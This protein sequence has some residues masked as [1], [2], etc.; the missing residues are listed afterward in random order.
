MELAKLKIYV[1][2]KYPNFDQLNPIE[3][4]F[5]P[6][7]IE[8]SKTGWQQGLGG[9]LVAADRSA[10]LSLELFF[11]T[12]LPIP[13]S[14]GFSLLQPSVKDIGLA[15]LP[16]L[17]KFKIEKDV[18]DYTQRIYQ[19]TQKRGDLD[20]RPPICQLVWGKHT[21]LFQGVLT[22]LTKSFTKFSADGTP[23]RATLR[24]SFEEWE[25]PATT[26]KKINPIDDPVRVVKRGETL[27]SIAAEEYNDP[28][29]WRIIAVTN[30]I[31]NPRRLTP[32]QRLTVPPLPSNQ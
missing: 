14:T 15:L 1:E 4:L 30:K 19:L 25:P 6:N 24:C 29:L 9:N 20:Q 23:I 5:N 16:G 28:N 18:R 27:S 13:K 22:Q 26:Q 11:D 8:I 17:P 10:T 32:G 3:A 2:Q 21:V 12:S 31:D 7:R